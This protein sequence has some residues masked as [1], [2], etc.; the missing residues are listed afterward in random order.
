MRWLHLVGQPTMAAGHLP[1]W[2]DRI[3]AERAGMALQMADTCSPEK[4]NSF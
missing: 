4:H 2:R 3:P 1:R